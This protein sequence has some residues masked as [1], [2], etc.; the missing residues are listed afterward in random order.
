M[1]NALPPVVQWVVGVGTGPG[2]LTEHLA[3]HITSGTRPSAESQT[4]ESCGH[5]ARYAEFTRL[6]SS[7]K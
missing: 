7:K 1:R 5:R 4:E 3:Y 6:C 2:V